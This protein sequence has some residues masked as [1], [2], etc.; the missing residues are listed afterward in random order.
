MGLVVLRAQSCW[1]S[2][3]G[4][5]KLFL[6]GVEKAETE[7]SWRRTETQLGEKEIPVRYKEN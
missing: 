1:T 3:E 4:N 6:V 7:A 5:D 2:R